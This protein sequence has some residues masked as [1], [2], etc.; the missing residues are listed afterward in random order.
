MFGKSDGA[1]PVWFFAV[2]IVF[3]VTLIIGG[4]RKWS[5]FVESGRLPRLLKYFFLFSDEESSD[6]VAAFYCI[7]GVIS[8]LTGLLGLLLH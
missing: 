4:L 8:I 2:L 5:Y 1:I 6:Y 3:G 7:G